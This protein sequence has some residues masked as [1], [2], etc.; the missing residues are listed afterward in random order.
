[1]E[2]N[3]GKGDLVRAPY[4]MLADHLSLL[5]TLI[6]TCLVIV[7]CYR[8]DILAYVLGIP[9]TKLPS[10]WPATPFLTAVLLLTKKRTWPVLIAAG[11]MAMTLADLRNGAPPRFMIWFSLGNFLEVLIAAFGFSYVAGETLHLGS[12]KDL[13][14]YLCFAVILAPLVSALVGSLGSVRG[15][16]WLQWRLWLF[17]DILGFLT[18]TPAILTWV[19]QGREWARKS[20]NYPELGALMASVVVFG[21]LAFCT[22]QREPPA[23]LYSLVPLLLWAAL[24]LCAW[25]EGRVNFRDGARSCGYLGGGA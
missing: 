8:A 17:S 7:V 14:E 9:P 24:R 13:A 12:V 18:V 16:Y 6:L 25:L 20:L 1:M 15:G 23:L 3:K 19:S 10:F 11:Q 2:R 4:W 21:Y 22:M 5:S